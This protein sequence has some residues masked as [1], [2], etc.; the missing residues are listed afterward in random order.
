[1]SIKVYRNHALALLDAKTTLGWRRP[2]PT[3]LYLPDH[4]QAKGGYVTVLV[5]QAVGS[6]NRE[7]VLHTDG[8]FRTLGG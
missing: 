5:A 4:P 7:Y 1:M 3:K 2:H 8:H 6:D